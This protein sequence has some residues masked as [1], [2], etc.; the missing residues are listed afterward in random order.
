M[1]SAD[2]IF[3]HSQKEAVHRSAQHENVHNIIGFFSK[4]ME[5]EREDDVAKAIAALPPKWLK[6]VTKSKNDIMN[7]EIV[8]NVANHLK[9]VRTQIK[10]TPAS[11]RDEKRVRKAQYKDLLYATVPSGRSSCF[12]YMNKQILSN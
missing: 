5:N 4:N 3:V 10:N 1:N 2:F 8:S 7:A 6:F 11:E 9:E 12:V